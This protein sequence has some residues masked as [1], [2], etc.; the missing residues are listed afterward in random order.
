VI[1]KL[2]SEA[3]TKMDQAVEHTAHEFGGIRTGRA[4]AGI[5]NRVVVDYYGTET[6]LQQLANFSVPEAR[7]LIVQPFD[8]TSIPAIER[9]I[10]TADLGLNPSNDGNIIRLAFPALTEERRRELIKV[11]HGIAED[12]KVAVRN[13]RRH[14][15]DQIEAED[16]SE[17][18]IHRA[19]K[20]LQELTDM[21]TAKIDEAVARKEEEL[22]EV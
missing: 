12:G 9:G 8:K 3:N 22:L 6:P 17:D 2:L 18:D 10:Q 4:N 14:S 21:H 16:V 15:K 5:L 13:V 20:R 7:M 1:N 11:V 19:E